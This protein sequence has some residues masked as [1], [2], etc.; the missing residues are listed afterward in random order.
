MTP[1][2]SCKGHTPGAKT[3]SKGKGKGRAQLAI[4]DRQRED[5]DEEEEKPE[6]DQWTALLSKAK[7][8]KDLAAALKADCNDALEEAEK[9]KRITKQGKKDTKELLQKLQCQEKVLK[10]ILAKGGQPMSLK[11]AKDCLIATG[12]ALKAAKDEAKELGQLA[13]KAASRASKK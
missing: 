3:L 8:A 1:P 11:K 10:Q 4:E 12:S 5:D 9:A 7:R 13:H 2:P 6:E